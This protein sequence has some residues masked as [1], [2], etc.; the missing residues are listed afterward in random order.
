MSRRPTQKYRVVPSNDP[1]MPLL[2]RA[3][4][5]LCAPRPTRPSTA[6]GDNLANGGVPAADASLSASSSYPKIWE[7]TTSDSD[8]VAPADGLGRDGSPAAGASLSASSSDPKIWESTTSGSEDAAAVSAGNLEDDGKDESSIEGASLTASSSDPKIWESTT[9]GSEGTAAV[10]AGNLEYDGMDKS[11]MAA[12]S[13]T[14]SSS[15]P[16]I[17]E[18]TTSGSEQHAD[19]APEPLSAE[20][21]VVWGPSKS[22]SAQRVEGSPCSLASHDTA[23]ES[24]STQGSRITSATYG[25]GDGGAA[26]TVPQ[27]PAF[28]LE[29]DVAGSCVGLRGKHDVGA[30]L[31]AGPASTRKDAAVAAAGASAGGALVSISGETPSLAVSCFSEDAVA[32]A[33]TREASGGSRQLVAPREPLFTLAESDDEDFPSSASSDTLAV[34]IWK[35]PT[36]PTDSFE[37]QNPPTPAGGAGVAGALAAAEHV[38]E[39]SQNEV[40]WATD[41]LRDIMGDIP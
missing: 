22:G 2:A 10:S 27:A 17:W 13:L 29:R 4:P 31:L 8:T 16:K 32:A 19:F 20:D 30:S 28:D 23:A 36:S 12:A 1:E 7:S 6:G 15:D 26:L 25:D 21:P 33:A 9:S 34:V 11:S 40:M 39:A 41:P 35:R 5:S 38:E 14:A 18:S 3:R 24:G 37:Q